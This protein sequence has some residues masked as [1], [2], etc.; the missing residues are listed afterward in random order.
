LIEGNMYSDLLV[1]HYLLSTH[2]R[3]EVCKFISL[4]HVFLTKTII[5]EFTS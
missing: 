1:L 4:I 2:K 5:R 3:R